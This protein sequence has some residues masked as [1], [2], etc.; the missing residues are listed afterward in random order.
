MF[1]LGPTHQ[2]C[3][4][5]SP[6]RPMLGDSA[7]KVSYV[8]EG[9]CLILAVEESY[10]DCVSVVNLIRN[11]FKQNLFIELSNE[12][13]EIINT[14]SY[15]KD[16]IFLGVRISI[17]NLKHNAI[18]GHSANIELEAPINHLKKKLTQAGF[19]KDKKPVPKLV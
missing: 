14:S 18:N 3:V 13:F 8:R 19:L 9:E 5:I 7:V 10:S 2:R 15:K 1:P 6:R 16:I 4:G 11:F 17:S 12:V